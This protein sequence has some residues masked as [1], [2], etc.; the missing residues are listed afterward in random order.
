MNIEFLR[1]IQTRLRDEAVF[2]N[3][4]HFFIGDPEKFTE[5]EDEDGKYRLYKDGLPSCG[6]ASCIAGHAIGMVRE[7]I[8]IK[9]TQIGYG[10]T[11]TSTGITYDSAQSLANELLNLTSEESTWLFYGQWS[12]D[13]VMTTDKEQAIKAIDVLID[14][15]VNGKN[16]PEWR[17]VET[18]EFT[19]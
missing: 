3:M 14:C 6:T 1:K 9:E 10:M 16:L 17:E 15:H 13:G 11:V 5:H 19:E 7:T 4:A 18:W 8:G 12:E 2:F